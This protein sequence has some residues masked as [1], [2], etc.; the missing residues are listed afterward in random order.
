M[1]TQDR[2]ELIVRT[3]LLGLYTWEQIAQRCWTTK[4]TARKVFRIF[5]DTGSTKP[6]KAARGRNPA[7]HLQQEHLDFIDALVTKSPCLTTLEYCQVVRHF[8]PMIDSSYDVMKRAF[9]VRVCQARMPFP[10]APCV[11]NLCLCRILH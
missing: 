3:K 9:K 6:Q 4:L 11:N 8:Y 10:L 2:I 5:Q 7:A 1:L